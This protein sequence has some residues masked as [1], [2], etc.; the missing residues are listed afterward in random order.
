M[1]E[2]KKS[3]CVM[4]SCNSLT[5]V[6][7][8]HKAVRPIDPIY[9]RKHDLL[10]AGSSQGIIFAELLENQMDLLQEINTVVIGVVWQLQETSYA[11]RTSEDRTQSGYVLVEAQGEWASQGSRWGATSAKWLAYRS[12]LNFPWQVH[13]ILF[14]LSKNQAW[15]APNHGSRISVNPLQVQA[16]ILNILKV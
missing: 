5:T 13:L 7:S 11:A 14:Q 6:C 16:V 8:W 12:H 10:V 15:A 9:R 4:A 2:I 3:Y 1:D